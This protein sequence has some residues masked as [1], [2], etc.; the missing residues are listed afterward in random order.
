MILSFYCENTANPSIYHGIDDLNMTF[1]TFYVRLIPFWLGY[2]QRA[3]LFA[4]GTHLTTDSWF[5]SRA[6]PGDV[7]GLFSWRNMKFVSVSRQ[8]YPALDVCALSQILSMT[9]VKEKTLGSECRER[10]IS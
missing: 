8:K 6:C 3:H 2:S 4:T 9:K 1:M 5:D 7:Y 10:R